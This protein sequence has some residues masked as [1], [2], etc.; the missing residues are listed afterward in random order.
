MT[1]KITAFL[2]TASI[3]VSV[4]FVACGNGKAPKTEE[5]TQIETVKEMLVEANL[6]EV[7]AQ[8]MAE[9]YILLGGVPEQLSE[10][11]Y[12]ESAQKVTVIYDSYYTLTFLF[13]KEEAIDRVFTM[14]EKSEEYTFGYLFYLKDTVEIKFTYYLVPAQRY[15]Q[16]EAFVLA[17]LQTH[18][19]EATITLSSE[20]GGLSCSYYNV[21]IPGKRKL[22]SAQEE[23]T[24][25]FEKRYSYQNEILITYPNGTSEQGAVSAVVFVEDDFVEIKSMTVYYN[26][27]NGM[28]IYSE[29]LVSENFDIVE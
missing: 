14:Q 17:E 19:P 29:D 6:S 9:V 25:A 10:I 3:F 28:N 20:K 21:S 24:L 7:A 8:N 15:E 23:A 12:D 27:E 18:Y 22:Y 4:F 16:L 2:L 13:D 5:E 1:R 11:A 26:D